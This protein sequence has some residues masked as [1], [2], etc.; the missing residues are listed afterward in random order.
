MTVRSETNERV[1]VWTRTCGCGASESV[2]FIGVPVEPPVF[3][4]WTYDHRGFVLCPECG[5]SWVRQIE[6]HTRFES[7]S[8]R[9]GNQPKGKYQGSEQAESGE[10]ESG[11]YDIR[12]GPVVQTKTVGWHPSCKCARDGELKPIPCTVLDPFLG[13][14]TTLLVAQRLGRDGIG[15]E[16]KREYAEM[17]KDRLEKDAGMFSR[18]TLSGGA[19]QNQGDAAEDEQ[20]DLLGQDSVHHH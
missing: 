5:A 2:T 14:G 13:S 12:L 8:G 19:P 20:P 10:A 11:E 6:Q 4:G 16:S 17:A 18:V 1:T 3:D 9:A 15:I 7:G